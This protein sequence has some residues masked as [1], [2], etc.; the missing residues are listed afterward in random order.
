M[1]IITVVGAR[2]QLIKAAALSFEIMKNNPFNEVIVHTG[3]HFDYSMSD[4]FFEKLSI[5]K[6][7]F[8][9][10]INGGTHGDMTGKMLTELE[11]V[12]IEEKPNGVLVYGD[13]NSTLAGA[14]AAAKLHIPVFHVEAGLR[15][16]NKKM[17][18]EIN[19]ILTDHLSDLLFCPTDTSLMNLT[20]EGISENAYMCGDIMCDSVRMFS[21]ISE[22]TSNILENLS[23][24]KSEYIFSTIHRAENTDS[25]EKITNILNGL[26]KL[27][28]EF[29]TIL[30]LHPRTKN[31]IEKFGLSHLIAN[32]I[33]IEPLDYFD[34][35]KLVNHAKFVIT[36]SG[37][38][39]KECYMLQVPCL[40]VRPE[41]EWIETVEAGW[42]ILS[43]PTPEKMCSLVKDFVKPS[44]HPEL[45]GDGHTSKRIVSQ[46]LEYF[47]K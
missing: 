40:T 18:E 25:V 44:L 15:S 26:S 42:N 4:V 33:I 22:N 31:V 19:R 41:T 2:P 29:P 37:G 45:F 10:D 23:I 43:T 17:P 13:T 5:P 30:A 11:R 20:R 16:F 32:L 7:K 34:T 24:K 3:Q 12:F 39:Q 38:L 36:D 9:L 27:S 6:P 35:L 14:L 8:N 28:L 21:D 46:I 1:K 47:E